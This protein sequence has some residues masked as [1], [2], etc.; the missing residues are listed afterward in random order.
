MH[1][2][3]RVNHSTEGFVAR[4]SS[5]KTTGRCV[6]SSSIFRETTPPAV[7]T[8]HRVVDGYY[9]CDLMICDLCDQSPKKSHH[10]SNQIF[11]HFFFTFEFIY[12]VYTEDV[13]PT[14]P[15]CALMTLF[16]L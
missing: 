3:A 8:S 6:L 15:S 13:D 4:Y 1:A 11:K 10:F 7:F 5:L 9:A 2:V 14:L 16:I 12:T